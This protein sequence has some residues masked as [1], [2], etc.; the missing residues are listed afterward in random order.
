MRIALI[1]TPHPDRYRVFLGNREISSYYHFVNRRNRPPIELAYLGAVARSIDDVE[2][3]LIEANSRGMSVTQAAGEAASINPDIVVAN[4]SAFDRWICPY[5]SLYQ[6]KELFKEVRSMLPEGILMVIGPH[7]EVFPE[8]TMKNIPQVDLGIIGEPESTFKVLLGNIAREETFEGVK[9]CIART[10]SG[11]V[12]NPP[13]PPIRDLDS[14]PLPSYE[15]L[16]FD[17]YKRYG[18][19]KS[20]VYRFPGKSSFILGSRGCSYN[21]IFCALY[22]HGHRFRSRSP[23]SIV[24]EMDFLNASYGVKIFRFQDPEFAIDRG[25]AIRICELI[26]DRNLDIKWSVEMRYDSANFE[27]L[28]SMRAAGCYHISYGLESGSQK[29][30]DAVNKKEKVSKA[31]NVIELTSSLD[32]HS[33]NN[34]VMGLPGE[35]EETINETIDF[36]NRNSKLPK[37]SFARAS[38]PVYYPGTELYQSGLEEGEYEPMHSWSDFVNVLAK[39]GL[40]LTDFNNQEEILS[41]IDRYNSEVRQITWRNRYG[42]RY[43]LNYRFYLGG[44]AKLRRKFSLENEIDSVPPLRIRR[45]SP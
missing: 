40:V 31:E 5:P 37:V 17:V 19:I 3:E 18:Y 15:D 4:T 26:S 45:S 29:I 12:L 6:V 34:I 27:L 16:P 42:N 24:D 21:C 35:S 38:L 39:S 22:I 20:E 32:I 25:R 14:L 1:N 7:I 30:L 44:L 23:H 11:L 10:G 2:I 36:I 28:E 13:R 33:S 8:A 41:Q 9:G 43:P